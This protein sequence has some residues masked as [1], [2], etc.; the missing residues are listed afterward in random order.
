MT[1]V[2]FGDDTVVIWTDGQSMLDA[3]LPVIK[4]IQFKN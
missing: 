3:S 4:S 1:L 2:D